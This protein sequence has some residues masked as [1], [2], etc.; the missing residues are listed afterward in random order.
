MAEKR[1]AVRNLVIVA[2]AVLVLVTVAAVSYKLGARHASN[3]SPAAARFE[4]GRTQFGGAGGPGFGAYAERGEDGGRAFVFGMG[5]RDL[6]RMHP[7]RFPVARFVPL[8]IGAT[9][10]GMLVLG[11]VAFFRTGGWRLAT[12][13]AAQT[14]RKKRS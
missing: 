4:A 11:V 8:L 9:L 6:G 7:A 1:P 3:F 2:L 5:A 10:F 13:S 12:A 14:S